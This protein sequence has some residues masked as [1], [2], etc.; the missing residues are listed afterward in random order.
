MKKGR[1]NVSQQDK[2]NY[3]Q[4]RMSAYE[5]RYDVNSRRQKQVISYKTVLVGSK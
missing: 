3:K 2:K 5:Q 4:E 1:S